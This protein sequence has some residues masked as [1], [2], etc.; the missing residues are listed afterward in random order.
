MCSFSHDLPLIFF[1]NWKNLF[2]FLA[3]RWENYNQFLFDIIGLLTLLSYSMSFRI[4]LSILLYFSCLHPKTAGHEVGLFYFG[5][6]LFQRWNFKTE[7]SVC[8]WLIHIFGKILFCSCHWWFYHIGNN[9]GVQ[10]GILGIRN[11]DLHTDLNQTWACLY[12][13]LNCINCTLK[14]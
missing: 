11:T 6:F 5:S 7:Y 13:L 1:T 12:W 9:C 2:Y 4:L 14:C 10:Q 3:N 8:M